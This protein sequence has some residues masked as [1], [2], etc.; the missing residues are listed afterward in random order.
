MNVVAGHTF[1]PDGKCSCGIARAQIKHVRRRHIGHPGWCHS[2]NL[3]EAEY[4]EIIKD[5]PPPVIYGVVTV[6]HGKENTI[7]RFYH[8]CDLQTELTGR[9]RVTVKGVTWFVA[10]CDKCGAAGR[11]SAAYPLTEPKEA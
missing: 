7:S 5:Q 2:G 4:L 11:L 3:N 9:D 8:E 1:D 10:E 6:T